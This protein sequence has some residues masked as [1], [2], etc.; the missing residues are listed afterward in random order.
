MQRNRRNPIETLIER[1]RR[2]H[3]IAQRPGQRPDAAIFIKVN[4]VAQHAF[5]SAKTVCRVETSQPVTAYAAAA[6]GIQWK[7]ILKRRAATD[8]EEFGAQRLGQ[9]Q[10]I[11]ANRKAAKRIYSAAAD[12]A[13]GRKDKGKKGAGS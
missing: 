6:L 1:Q 8:A 12:A 10:A 11:G 7:G 3:Q 4:Q 13:I 9:F 5:I 2:R